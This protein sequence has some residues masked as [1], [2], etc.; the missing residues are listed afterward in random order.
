MDTIKDTIVRHI[1]LNPGCRRRELPAWGANRPQMMEA[2]WE[3][4]KA[5]II[6]SVMHNDP[7]NMEHYY[8]YYVV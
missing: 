7:A 5:G 3:L 2:L 6:Y 1:Q 4:E 8:K